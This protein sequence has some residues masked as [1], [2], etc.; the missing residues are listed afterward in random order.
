MSVNITV[1]KFTVE[2]APCLPVSTPATGFNGSGSVE[3]K[4]Y[5]MARRIIV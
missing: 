3:K 4:L 5:Y 2:V 1:S